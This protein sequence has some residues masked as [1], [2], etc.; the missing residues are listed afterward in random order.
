MP[1]RRSRLA[2]ALYAELRAHLLA[3]R[4]ALP[5]ETAADLVAHLYDVLEILGAKEDAAK[6]ERLG[7]FARFS[8]ILADFEAVTRRAWTRATDGVMQLG[9]GHAGGPAF[10]R[11][12]AEYL[13]FYAQSAYEDF[14]GY[15]DATTPAVTV[16]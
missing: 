15:L 14:A 1:R 3:L 10:L 12:L 5:L 9:A 4:T 7:V 8:Q 2:P 13:S 6:V 11:A 16:N